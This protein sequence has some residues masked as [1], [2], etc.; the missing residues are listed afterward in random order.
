VEKI[1][2]KVPR[3]SLAVLMSHPTQFDGPLFLRISQAG[4]ID[5]TV[6]YLETDKIA[7][8]VDN[9]LGFSPNWDIAVTEGHRCFSCPQGSIRRLLFL[10]REC[11]A[12]HKYDLVIFPGYSTLETTLLALLPHRQNLGIRLDAAP[13]YPE[14]AWKAWCKRRVLRRLFRRFETFHPVGSLTEQFLEAL[15]VSRA[16]MF[17]FPYAVDN[18]YLEERANHFRQQ[19]ERILSDL[20]ISSWTF[21]VLGVLKFVP[22]ENPMELLRGF[23]LFHQKSRDSALILV[24]AGALEREVEAYIAANKL[25]GSVHPVGYARY[26][27]LPKWYGISNV[28]VHPAIRECWGVSVNEAMACGLPVVASRQVGSSYDLI[29]DGAN[30]YQYPSG[31]VKA[32]ADCLTRIASRPDRGAELGECSHRLIKEW[33]FEAT[34]RSLESAL[35][36]IRPEISRCTAS[37]SFS[38]VP[39]GTPTNQQDRYA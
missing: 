37:A 35:L 20:G 30:G 17:R 28:F 25:A 38:A 31:D 34:M 11:V 19:R 27:E 14:P 16:K 36:S 26:S 13:I 7:E 33:D 5:L 22:R 24:G 9:E 1:N 4:V 10:Y 32:L 21:V 2:P 12:G 3:F 18:A 23:H 6:Y 15:E 29:Q 8:K 39:E